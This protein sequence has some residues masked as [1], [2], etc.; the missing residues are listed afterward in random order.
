[1]VIIKSDPVFGE[2]IRAGLY[3]MHEQKNP[4]LFSFDFC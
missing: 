2:M 3:R 4:A 1:M